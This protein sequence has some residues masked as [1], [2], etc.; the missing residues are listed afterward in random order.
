MRRPRAISG[1]FNRPSAA[2]LIKR[3]TDDASA[4]VQMG[5][6]LQAFNT[7]ARAL[8]DGRGNRGR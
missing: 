3:T 5:R 8:F 6:S 1:D 4:A 7:H 2:L